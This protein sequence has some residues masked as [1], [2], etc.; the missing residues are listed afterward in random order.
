MMKKTI[1]FLVGFWSL[2]FLFSCSQD[3]NVVPADS[4]T[5]LES[6]LNLQAPSGEKIASSIQEL[7]QKLSNAVEILQDENFE[8]TSIRF[9]SLEYGYCAEIVFLDGNQQVGNIAMT[10]LNIASSGMLTQVKTRSEGGSGETITYC[11]NKGCTGTCGIEFQTGNGIEF[12]GCVC[13]GGTGK[14]KMKTKSA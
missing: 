7:K 8:I 1:Y 9:L 11:K 2:I 10:N 5:M 4:Q 12:G 13:D 6:S 3:E 14:C